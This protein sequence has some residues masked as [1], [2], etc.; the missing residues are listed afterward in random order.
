MRYVIHLTA[1]TEARN[2]DDAAYKAQITYRTVNNVHPEDEDCA[3]C[4][5]DLDTRPDD[6]L[7]ITEQQARV[8]ERL[9]R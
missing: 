6:Q 8:D 3:R 1:I 5:P 2:E 4:S 9:R 7:S